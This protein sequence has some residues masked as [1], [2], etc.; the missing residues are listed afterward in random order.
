M[1]EGW[2]CRGKELGADR[3]QQAKANEAQDV[4]KGGRAGG[5]MCARGKMTSKHNAEHWREAD[6]YMQGVVR[7]KESNRTKDMSSKL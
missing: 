7:L 2:Y 5:N 1:G 3:M 6:G 4:H